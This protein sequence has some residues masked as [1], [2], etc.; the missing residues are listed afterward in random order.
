MSRIYQM[1]NLVEEEEKKKGPDHIQK[2]R[3]ENLVK[4]L[5]SKRYTVLICGDYFRGVPVSIIVGG[6]IAGAKLPDIKKDFSEITKKLGIDY[7]SGHWYQEA[8]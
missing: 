5:K 2:G 6:E 4:E 1:F 3:G 7:Q 8:K